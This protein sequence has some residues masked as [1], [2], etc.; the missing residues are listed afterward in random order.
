M[1]PIAIGYT[2]RRLAAKC[3]NN[4]AISQLGD[5]LLP[6]QLGVATPG[7]CEA[8]VHATRRYMATMSDDS[9][10]VKLDFSNA[11]NCLHRDRMLKTVAD[12]MPC[13]YRF[14]WLSY[15][16]ATALKFGDSTIWSE[17]GPQ[18]GDP[19]GPLLFCLTI[20]PILQSLSSE[21]VLAYMDDVTLGGC[22][23]TVAD[24]ITTIANIGPS[25]GLQLNSSKCEVISNT[26]AVGHAVLAGFEH[27]TTDSATLLGA[28]IST[29]SAMTDC[30]AARCADLARA[31]ERLKLVSAHDALILL[32]NS[33]S[34]P[35]LLHTLCSACCADHVFLSKFDDQLRSAVCS[36]CNVSLTDDQWLQASLPVRNGGLGIRRVS[37]LASSAFLA[38]AAGTRELQDRILHRVSSVNDDIFDSCLSSRAD[39]GIQPPDVS[40]FHK[41]KKVG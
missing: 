31:V 10:L 23:S 7:G 24:D 36:I 11:F 8:A 14:C 33:I 1:R 39:N 27:K 30:L 3:A 17:E 29:G 32:K 40:N 18:Q 21:L 4:Y 38:S 2:W 19:L 28:P 16:N 26:G 15:S 25:Y 5:T 41:Q 35:K 22:E 34:A 9:V 12:Q 37:S 20:Q 6:M 13:I